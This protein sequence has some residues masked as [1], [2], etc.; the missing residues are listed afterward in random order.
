MDNLYFKT[1]FIG[2]DSNELYEIQIN[3]FLLDYREIFY[4]NNY[5]FYNFYNFNYNTITNKF[6]IINDKVNFTVKSLMYIDMYTNFINIKKFI[7]KKF[8]YKKNNVYKL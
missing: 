3:E 2:D 7:N 6:S 1:F 8:I 4:L 5:L